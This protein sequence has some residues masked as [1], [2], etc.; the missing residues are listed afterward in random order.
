LGQVEPQY[1]ETYTFY[2]QSDEKVRLWV[3]GQMLVDNWT[4]HL[5][6]EDK[7]TIA[8]QAGQKYDIKLEYAEETGDASVQLL[9]SSSSQ[10]EEIIPQN[11]LYPD[12]TALP[13]DVETGLEYASGQLL[14]QLEPDV[15]DEQVQSLAQDYGITGIERLVPQRSGTSSPLN[16]WRILSFTPTSDLLKARDGLRSS[17]G[18]KAVGF[19]YGLELTADSSNISGRLWSLN[20]TGQADD[21]GIS[22]KADADIDAP[23]AW[24]LQKRKKEITVAVIDTGVDYTHPALQ[25]KMW[26]N[27]K[28]TLNGVDDDAN[29]YIDDIYG[30]DFGAEDSNPIDN[31]GH[32]THVAGIIAANGTDASGSIVGVS[33]NA[34]IMALKVATGNVRLISNAVRAVEYA[35][36]EGARVINASWGMLDNFWVRAGASIGEKIPLVGSFFGISSLGSLT[37]AIRYANNAQVLFVAT[38]GNDDESLDDTNRFPAGLDLPNVITVTSTD[39]KDDQTDNYSKTLVDLGAPGRDIYS[40]LPGGGYGLKSGTSMAAPHVAGAAAVLLGENDSLTAAVLRQILMSSGDP[41][42]SLTD[43]TVSGKRLNLTNALNATPLQN[44]GVRVTINQVTQVDNLDS[45]PVADVPDFLPLVP[46]E[47]GKPDRADFFPRVS[48]GGEKFGGESFIISEKDDIRPS[49]VFN[50]TEKLT[51]STIEINIRIEDSDDPFP[52][53]VVDINP[54][55]DKK[56]LELIYNLATGEVI[57]RGSGIKFLRNSDG[58]LE[59]NGEF[60]TDK[61]KIWFSIE[62]LLP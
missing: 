33:P 47:I 15:T 43:K 45:D 20:N 23:E 54:L 30:Y 60:D 56:D 4:S 25:S 1:S 17:T 11:V 6:T 58:Q 59:I 18:I 14:V 48:I 41:I 42:A 53:D 31:A 50:S 28:E 36:A 29:G 35:V 61:G 2:T 51:A 16:Q 5:K 8:L 7:G 37:D 19:D 27:S 13:L 57:D 21:Q 55:K 24:A 52:D 62:T 32:G 44:P 10:L 9:W 49:W 22:G 40:T 34:K 12:P 46:D 3:N 26:I 39:R 38:A